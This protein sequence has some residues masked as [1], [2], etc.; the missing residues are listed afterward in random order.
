MGR[1]DNLADKDRLVLKEDRLPALDRL[2]LTQAFAARSRPRSRSEGGR[3]PSAATIRCWKQCYCRW[4]GHLNRVGRLDPNKAPIDRATDDNLDSFFGELVAAG[5]VGNTINF[6]FQGL[7][8]AYQRMYPGH[9]FKYIT[10]AD[11]IS[12]RQQLDLTPRDIQPPALKDLVRLAQDCFQRGLRE[13]TLARRYGLIQDAA[14]Q[15]ILCDPPPRRRALGEMRAGTHLQQRDDGWWLLIEPSNTKKRRVE[16]HRLEPWIWPIVERFS[17]ER[18]ELL[19]GR[20]CDSLWLKR[21]VVKR[22]QWHSEK[23]FG[24]GFG[25]HMYR[26]AVAGEQA[27]KPSVG[28]FS[29]S[30]KLGHSDPRSTIPYLREATLEGIA[31]RQ[32]VTLEELR[33]I[34]R[35]LA[36]RRHRERRR[37]G[38]KQ[39]GGL[40]DSS[41]SRAG[42]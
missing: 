32:A 15:A 5:L 30:I 13:T 29:P 40:P 20:S 19:A 34:T 36:E 22:I 3:L 35:P 25:P 28:P 37:S 42:G 2:A 14:I 6:Y 31:E 10:H 18:L 11:G 33:A 21:G 12:L 4:A 1:W 23:R 38:L 27:R 41:S 26:Y 17:I 8:L 16:R 39:T 9:D 24:K 7:R